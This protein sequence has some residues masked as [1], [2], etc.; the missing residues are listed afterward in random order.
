MGHYDALESLI[1]QSVK[2]LH[3]DKGGQAMTAQEQARAFMNRS[4]GESKS[5]TELFMELDMPGVTY[6]I[7]VDELTQALLAAKREWLQEA[8]R[9]VQALCNEE[10]RCYIQDK[11]GCNHPDVEVVHNGN[12]ARVADD[13][14]IWCR[15]QAAALKETV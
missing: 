15:A 14:R 2:R 3:E 13:F 1:R 4:S 6:D 9:K 10:V 5:W 12:A 11:S 7:F 8:Q